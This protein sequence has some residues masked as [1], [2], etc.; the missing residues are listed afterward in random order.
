MDTKTQKIL[1]ESRVLIIDIEATSLDTDTAVTR[2]VGVKTNQSNKIHC[3]WAK[4]FDKLRKAIKKADFIVT[5]NGNNYDIPVLLNDYNKLFKYETSL[6]GKHIDLYDVVTSREATFGTNFLDGYSLDAVCKTLGLSRKVQD[7]DYNLL[8]N[9][10]EDMT[11]DEIEEIEYYLRQDIEITN[12][13]Y[14]F[15]EEMYQPLALFLPKND[16]RK[17]NYIKS[18]MGAITYKVICHMSG[19]QPTYDGAYVDDG[20]DTYKGGHVFEPTKEEAVGNIKCVDYTSA[21]P[22]AYMQANLYTKCKHCTEGECQYRYTGG[23][24]PDGHTLE[25]QG[26]YCTRGG[27]G[28]R[29]R[30]IQKLFLLRLDAKNKIKSYQ[31]RKNN[32]EILSEDEKENLNY[33]NKFQQGLKIII[34][35]IYGISGSPKFLQTYDADTAA[36][37]TKICRFNLLYLHHKLI[38]FENEHLYGDT[39]SEYIICPDDLTDDELQEQLNEII[40]NLKSI[41]PFPQDTFK[42]DIEDSMK[43]M[44]FFSDGHGEFKKKKYIMVMDDDKVKVKGLSIVR[45]DSSFLARKIWNENIKEYISTNLSHKIPLSYIDGWISDAIEDD[46]ENAAIEFKV[47]PLD[48]YNSN[49]SIHSKISEELGEGKHKLIKNRR[50]I[51]IGKGVSYATLDQAKNFTIADIDLSRVYSD[52]SDVTDDAQKTFTR[53]MV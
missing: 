53:F 45:R 14:E 15:I 46:I 11:Q 35:T 24:T 50:G 20:S 13:L 17:K 25:L 23:T 4:D 34:N 10:Y 48:M 12:E 37:C 40:T 27:M 51:G 8:K 29:E 36:D 31:K 5:Y 7:F 30:V 26:E 6:T 33:L 42:I 22:H 39:D 52:L 16:V 28:V 18:S 9:E 19:L 21:Y 32:G 41:Y 49:T 43:F 38:E 47:K 1:D 3:I 2:V 44:G